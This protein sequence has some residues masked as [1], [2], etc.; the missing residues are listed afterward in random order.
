MSTKDDSSRTERELHAILGR[1]SL[2]QGAIWIGLLIN[3]NICLMRNHYR[4]NPLARIA[5][6][7]IDRKVR[8]ILAKISSGNDTPVEVT[9]REY[10]EC[11]SFVY[12]FQNGILGRYFYTHISFIN[13]LIVQFQGVYETNRCEQDI[14]VAKE[15]MRAMVGIVTKHPSNLEDDKDAYISEVLNKANEAL[16]VNEA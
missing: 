14:E 16:S 6:W 12:D 4:W 5:I 10:E 13:A 8:A 7:L 2:K 1:M 11:R 9:V 3:D 15:L